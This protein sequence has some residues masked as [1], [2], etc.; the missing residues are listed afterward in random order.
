MVPGNAAEQHQLRARAAGHV[1]G[2][3]RALRERARERQEVLRHDVALEA[4]DDRAGADAD[5]VAAVGARGDVADGRQGLHEVVGRRAAEPGR[6]AQL[7]GGE[8]GRAAGDLVEKSGRARHRLDPRLDRAGGRRR[9]L[10][11]RHLAYAST[12]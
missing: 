9:I 10:A 2:L 1:R 3:P 6:R 4:L 7:L 8:A 12:I 5:P 11:G